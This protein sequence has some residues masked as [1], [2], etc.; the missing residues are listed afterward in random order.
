MAARTNKIRLTDNWR[1]K[2]KIGVI[3]DRMVRHVDG[4][5]E[6]TNSQIKAAEILLRKVAP[7]LARTELTGEDGGP[8]QIKV[9][10]AKD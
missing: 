7:D 4:E 2:I 8:Q 9:T 10:W 1:E 5:V 6:M 3:I